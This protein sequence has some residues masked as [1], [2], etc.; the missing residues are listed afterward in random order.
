MLYKKYGTSNNQHA[1]N[2]V[3]E[4]KEKGIA[5]T[6]LDDLF[7]GKNLLSELKAYTEAMLPYAKV[8]PDKPFLLQINNY[9]EVVDFKNPFIRLALEPNILSIV[10]GYLGMF[11]KFHYYSLAVATPVPE[12]II[13][14]K[15]QRWHRDFEDKILCKMFIYLSDVD[16]DSG[17]FMYIRKSNYG[18]IW[19]HVFP[20]KPAKGSYPDMNEVLQKI[21]QQEMLECHGKAGTVIFADTRGLHRGGYAK[22]NKR[23]MFTAEYASEGAFLMVRHRYSE[24]AKK[25]LKNEAAAFAVRESGALTHFIKRTSCWAMRMNKDASDF[26]MT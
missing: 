26:K 2:I 7:P 23:I 21:P 15:S 8:R 24:E 4:L 10:N 5:I 17:P 16:Q 22:K 6:N 14:L 9:N 18:R 20:P 11:S 25:G 3:K 13:P 19:S 12:G 1:K